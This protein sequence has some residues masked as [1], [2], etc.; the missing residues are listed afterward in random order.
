[1]RRIDR[2]VAG[3]P[4][5][6]SQSRPDFATIK[7]GLVASSAAM[8]HFGIATASLKTSTKVRQIPELREKQS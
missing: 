6:V 5:I 8:N 3:C 1:M 2:L 7:T 4:T